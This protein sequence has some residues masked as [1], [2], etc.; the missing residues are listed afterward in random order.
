MSALRKPRRS[1]P[2][3]PANYVE[4]LEQD[5]GKVPQ[6]LYPHGERDVGP[7]EIPTSWYL[8]RSIHEL[9]VER[10]WKRTWQ[11]ACREEDIANVGDTWVY[12]IANTS[13]VL[14]RVTSSEIKAF[15]NA[16]LHRGV[17]LRKGPGRVPY[18]KCPFH[19]FTWNL[20]GTLKM[21]P[22]PENFPHIKADEFR[23]PEVRVGRWGGFVFI[24][25]DPNAP[26]FDSYLGDFGRHFARYPYENRIKTLHVAKVFPC[27]WKLL[28]EAFMEAWHVLTTH[29]Q[30]GRSSGER[31]NQQEAWGN[32]SRGIVASCITSDY[33]PETPSPQE[34]YEAAMGHWDDEP[35][36]PRLP[37]GM[38][39][40]AAFAQSSRG[41]LRPAW[42]ALV[43]E[44]SD[45]EMIDIFYYTLFPN[46]NPF[47]TLQPLVYRF[48]PNGDDHASSIMD[49]MM[50][51]PVAK[52]GERPIAAEVRWLSSSEDFT[53]V[54]ELGSLGAFVSQDIANLSQITKGLRNNQRGKVV[55]AKD[56]EL[57]IRHFYALWQQAMGL[58]ASGDTL[59]SPV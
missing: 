2:S 25:L 32:Y 46:F 15:Y 36:L 45:A 31:C 14:A 59:V 20:N 43:D 29:P 44:L 21:V 37:D 17:A 47:G 40:R 16:C 41:L 57:K 4:A 42:G 27:N 9:E 30:Y 38:S 18:L 51:T 52:E 10:I 39:S 12:D 56:Q 58:S 49:L 35:P 26:S 24:N 23:L 48:R 1:H 53:A 19:G 11:M 8:E 22:C 28:Q 5:T 7:L 33:I 50:I 13:I 3:Q 34:V 6:M 54:P 55:F